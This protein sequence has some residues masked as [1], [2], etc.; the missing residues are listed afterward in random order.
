[1]SAVLQRHV[2]LDESQK[3]LVHHGGCLQGVAAPFRPH[4]IA[5]QPAKL[6]IDKGRQP[7]QGLGIAITPVRQQ[8]RE[9]RRHLHRR[10]LIA[11]KTGVFRASGSTPRAGRKLSRCN[12]RGFSRECRF[13]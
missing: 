10:S 2:S 4:V 3:G 8:L 11:A 12:M 7:L 5:R 13:T 1:M 9:I 6:L